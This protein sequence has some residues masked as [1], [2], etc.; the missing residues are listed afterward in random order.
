MD[1]RKIE[2]AWLEQVIANPQ[3][4]LRPRD[5]VFNMDYEPP[6]DQRALGR[7]LAERYQVRSPQAL[8]DCT[9]CHR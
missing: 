2:I 8:T 5:Q 9:T 3:Q 4:Y 6:E 1:P 7:E